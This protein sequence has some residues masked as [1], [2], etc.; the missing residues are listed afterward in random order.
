MGDKMVAH[1]ML[2]NTIRRITFFSFNRQIDMKQIE[3]A[4]HK[5]F[6]KKLKDFIKGDTSGDYENC[7][8]ALLD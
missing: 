3:E 8:I 7:L 5:M 1:F 4:F 2:D 6:G